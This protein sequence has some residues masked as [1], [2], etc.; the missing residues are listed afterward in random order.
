MLAPAGYFFFPSK[1]N[2]L[3]VTLHIYQFH[4]LLWNDGEEKRK[5]NVVH[6]ITLSNKK[7][8]TMVTVV[9]LFILVS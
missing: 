5:K 3:F 1:Y 7:P 9:V 2:P 8:Y 4:C 6:G